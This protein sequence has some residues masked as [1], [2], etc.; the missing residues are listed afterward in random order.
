MSKSPP[1]LA[2]LPPEVQALFAAQAAE[3]GRKDTEMLGL[4]LRHA[5]A[6]RRLMDDWR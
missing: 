4:S 3:L 2:D 6:Q 1:I 5:T